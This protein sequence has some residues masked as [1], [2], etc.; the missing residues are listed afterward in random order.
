MQEA[1]D[2]ISLFTMLNDNSNTINFKIKENTMVISSQSEMGKGYE[3]I[4][5]EGEGE[6]VNISFN[7]RY[8]VDVLKIIEADIVV[9]EFTGPLSPCIVRPSETDNFIYLLLPVRT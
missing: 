9:L 3:Q 8:M 5:V 4:Y 1:I 7:A 2:R 6:A